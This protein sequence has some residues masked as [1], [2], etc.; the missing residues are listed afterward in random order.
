[1]HAP[2]RLVRL[3][4]VALLLSMVLLAMGDSA[5]APSNA[6][7]SDFEVT[8]RVHSQHGFAGSELTSKLADIVCNA[9]VDRDADAGVPDFAQ[10]P[11]RL[12][13][14]AAGS[15]PV[16]EA[17]PEGLR[18]ELVPGMY[19]GSKTPYSPA[20][21]L[22]A[23]EVMPPHCHLVRAIPRRFLPAPHLCITR[24][25]PQVHLGHVGRHGSRHGTRLREAVHVHD[26]LLQVRS[27]ARSPA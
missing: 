2:W 9:L 7:T 8:L 16:P 24:L 1:M 15:P 11:A 20:E 12:T 18:V 4:W 19:L 23:L 13:P 10:P 17:A 5:T 22:D 6:S 25:T 14:T 21:S 26:S 3:V 27:G